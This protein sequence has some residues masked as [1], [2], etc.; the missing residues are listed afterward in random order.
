[1]RVAVAGGAVNCGKPVTSRW[2]WPGPR[3]RP[4]RLRMAHQLARGS[5][6]IV[7]PVRLPGAVGKAMTGGALLPKGEHSQAEWLEDVR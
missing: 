6:K 1:M 2:C 7:V 5:R 4:G 3:G